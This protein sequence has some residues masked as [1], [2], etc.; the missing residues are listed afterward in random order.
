MLFDMVT[1]IFLLWQP[2]WVLLMQ[3][4]GDH[5][6][7]STFEHVGIHIISMLLSRSFVNML[8]HGHVYI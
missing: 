2:I 6:P 7:L 8:T 3:N 5:Q 4:L 1:F